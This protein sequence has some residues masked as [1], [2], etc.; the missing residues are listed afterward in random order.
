MNKKQSTPPK[1]RGA[2]V[3]AV[4]CFVAAIAIAGTYTLGNSREARQKEEIART[5]ENAAKEKS[6]GD[7]EE[8]ARATDGLVIQDFSD[9]GGAGEGGTL[10]KTPG[11]GTG[12]GTGSGTGTGAG[13]GEDAGAGAD[14]RSS[15]NAESGSTSGAQKTAG[16]GTALSFSEDSNLVWPVNGTV[17]MSYS[18]DKTIYFST[19]DQYKYNPAL[20]ISAAENDQV[21]AGTAGIVKSID[22]SPETG[23]TVNIDIGSGY[24]LFYGQLKDIQLKVGDYV[25]ANTV[26]G[27]VN[28]PTKY[29]SV[30]GSNVYFEMRKDG[31]PINPVDYM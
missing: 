18:M 9:T 27:Y 3:A 19:L 2:T 14:D 23:T 26:I 29:Y 17:L 22:E 13:T 31:Q 20:I 21:I 10:E 5:E 28:T 1:K 6:N 25:E 24:E 8:K 4:L 7:T 16:T 12:T 15:T 11:I 30:E